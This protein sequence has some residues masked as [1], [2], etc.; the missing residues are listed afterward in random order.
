MSADMASKSA[1]M[2]QQ[3]RQADLGRLQ[4]LSGTYQSLANMN[5]N[6]NMQAQQAYGRAIQQQRQNISNAWKSLADMGGMAAGYGLM[7]AGSPKAKVTP[8]T[9]ETPVTTTPT[10]TT[11]FRAYENPIG[12]ETPESWYYKNV[13]QNGFKSPQDYYYK[14]VYQNGTQAPSNELQLPP[15]FI[16]NNQ[17]QQPQPKFMVPGQKYGSFMGNPFV[18]DSY[19]DQ[20]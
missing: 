1:M 15:S 8:G 18:G 11:G 2:A 4:S 20:Y 5:V 13:Y 10:P 9:T 19:D 12:P 14:N 17:Y 16:L 7:S 6:A 3:N